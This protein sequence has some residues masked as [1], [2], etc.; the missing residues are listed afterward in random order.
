VPG[1]LGL[2]SQGRKLNSILEAGKKA[3]IMEGVLLTGL[4]SGLQYN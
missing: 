4:L 2:L 1:Q 3:E